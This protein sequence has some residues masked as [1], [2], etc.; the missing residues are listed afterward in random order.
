MDWDSV[1][2]PED[3]SWYFSV[4]GNTNAKLIIVRPFKASST[5]WLPWQPPRTYNHP[6][7]AMLGDGGTEHTLFHWTSQTGQNRF[8][9][10]CVLRR[11]H[12]WAVVWSQIWNMSWTFIHNK[13]IVVDNIEHANGTQIMSHNRDT[14]FLK[15][16][17]CIWKMVYFCSP[18]TIFWC[19]Q[20]AFL[21]HR[22]FIFNQ[23]WE[24]KWHIL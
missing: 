4:I 17:N 20:R 8:T 6:C 23:V 9:F 7:V 14:R 11:D 5:L 21:S 3:C 10:K 2:V 15:V 1:S 24:S 12:S 18:W 19:L 13:C 16:Q 22:D